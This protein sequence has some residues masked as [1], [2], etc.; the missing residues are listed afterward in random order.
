MTPRR[1][2]WTPDLPD[3]RDYQFVGPV[4]PLPPA[5]DLRPHCPPVVDQ[6][7]VGC[8]E[9]N[10][11]AGALGLLELRD[12]SLRIDPAMD[13][14][15]SFLPLSRMFIYYN[16]RALEG[17]TDRD[18]G[19]SIRDGIKV[20][21][22]LGV[23]TESTWPY[24]AVDAI[25][26][27]ADTFTKPSDAAYAEAAAH[28]ITSYLSVDNSDAANIKGALFNGFPVVFGFSVFPSF[29]S[30]AVAFDG[31][32]PMPTSA[33]L[34]DGALGGHAVLCVGYDDARGVFIVRN[35]WG[36][37]WGDGGY[38]YFPYAY[39]TDPDLADDFWIL[40]K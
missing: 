39:L 28:K 17:T 38:C 15:A 36:A 12:L 5:V 29:E 37:G 2:T 10:A 3:P 40:K 33:D 13:F 31:K 35:S 27:R 16:S 9:G 30:Q 32:V 26:S 18:A 21:A 24:K 14:A 25:F 23:C 34:D 7:Q 11:L 1:Y 22:S 20:L 4:Q 6:G 8:C 19:A